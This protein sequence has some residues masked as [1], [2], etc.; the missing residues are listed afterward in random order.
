M[1]DDKPYKNLNGVDIKRVFAGEIVPIEPFKLEIRRVPI[2]E[3]MEQMCPICPCGNPESFFAGL[4]DLP[5]IPHFDMIEHQSL[6]DA[7]SHE[8]DDC[9][10]FEALDKLSED[11]GTD[12]ENE[13]HH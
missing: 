9:K 3:F 5:E 6:E 13:N 11:G 12:D 8:E 1:N 2:D 7:R 4:A 10:V